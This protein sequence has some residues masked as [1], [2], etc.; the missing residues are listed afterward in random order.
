[1]YF[2]GWKVKIVNTSSRHQEL[3]RALTPAPKASS[4]TGQPRWALILLTIRLPFYGITS[5]QWW[6]AA[7]GKIFSRPAYSSPGWLLKY[8]AWLL[9]SY[10]P[11]HHLFSLWS[12]L[13]LCAQAMCSLAQC[14][15]T[16][17]RLRRIPCPNLVK[18]W[19]LLTSLTLNILENLST[20]LIYL[21]I[22]FCFLSR[23][24][25]GISHKSSFSNS[26][27]QLEI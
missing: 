10:Q 5:Q 11:T 15:L 23:L 4:K 19:S 3:L 12:L 27:L 7:G 9:T 14:H 16:M 18:P 21:A 17:Q 20:C 2:F 25:L 24:V 22:I 1:M 26:P 8:L 6:A 13:V